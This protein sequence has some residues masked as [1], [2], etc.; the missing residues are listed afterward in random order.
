[1][2][3]LSWSVT[4][5]GRLNKNVQ[6]SRHVASGAFTTS[7]SAANVTGLS[8]SVGDVVVVHADEAMR[9]GFGATAATASTG[10]YLAAGAHREFEISPNDAG[11]V[12]AIDVA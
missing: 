8:P 2:G 4:E 1:M 5:S 9:I 7:P 3:T 12:S 6:S 11:A 10:H